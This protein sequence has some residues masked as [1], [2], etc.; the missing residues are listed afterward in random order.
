[1]PLS[2]FDHPT[3]KLVV[4]DLTSISPEL[5][6][7]RPDWAALMFFFDDIDFPEGVQLGDSLTDDAACFLGKYLHRLATRV[8]SI[9]HGE[10][11]DLVC[12][13]FSDPRLPRGFTHLKI[14]TLLAKARGYNGYIQAK[15]ELVKK[16]ALENRLRRGAAALMHFGS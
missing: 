11:E 5:I 10:F 7:S 1:M 3:D 2:F 12:S 8:S 9:A 15:E 16:G 14:Y 6:K 4:P 13:L